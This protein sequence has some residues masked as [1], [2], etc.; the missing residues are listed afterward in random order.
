MKICTKC[1]KCKLETE[2]AKNGKNGLHARCKQCA[3]EEAKIWRQQNPEIARKRDRIKHE[4]YRAKR[5]EKMREYSQNNAIQRAEVER[6]RYEKEP[7]KIK[8][9]NYTYRRNNP[10]LVQAWNNGRRASEKRATPK[11][12]NYQEISKFYE[13]AISM[14]IKTGKK[15]HVDHIIPL[16][17][18]NVCGLHVQHNLQVICAIENLKKGCR[19]DNA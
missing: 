18:K 7:N 13:Q 19:F 6:K 8:L 11:W 10:A 5:L 17:G 12:V 3:C 9:R 15:Y 2:F 16:R 1:K 4:K 14:S